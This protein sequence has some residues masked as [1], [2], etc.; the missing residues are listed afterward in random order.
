MGNVP[1]NAVKASYKT[2][3]VVDRFKDFLIIRKIEKL[4]SRS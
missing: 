2:R 3:D 4:A 1:T